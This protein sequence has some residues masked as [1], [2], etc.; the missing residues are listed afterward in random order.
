MSRRRPRAD[1]DAGE[2]PKSVIV[3]R[4]PGEEIDTL[5]SV[6]EQDFHVHSVIL[7]CHSNYFRKFLD[8]PD[9]IRQSASF[10]FR[11]HY[12]GYSPSYFLVFRV[13]LGAPGV[14]EIHDCN[15]MGLSLLQLFQHLWENEI[16]MNPIILALWNN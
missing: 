12:S 1:S 7:K 2:P 13:V 9:K 5:L 11:Y 16:D 10:Q 3:F 14:A 15:L 6:L 8:S 4:S